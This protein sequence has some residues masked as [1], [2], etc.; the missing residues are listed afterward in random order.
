M[1]RLM[2][3]VAAAAL[4]VPL[5]VVPWDGPAAA[6]QANSYCNV[7]GASGAAQ[8][9]PCQA[10]APLAVTQGGPAS[11]QTAFTAAA[12]GTTGAVTLTIAAVAAKTNYLCGFDVSAI[13]G[14]AA[15]GPITLVGLAGVGGTAT[16]LTYQLASAAG[17]ALLSEKFSPCA[18]AN[19]TS[20]AVVITTTADGTASAVN[21]NA[22]G[23]QQ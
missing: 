23:F 21:V 18:P 22:W 20:L 6:E 10:K 17:G 7:P 19:S 15:V 2:G 8:W 4:M 13:G 12:A 16:T 11:G 1:N 9:V 5:A 14:T 3:S